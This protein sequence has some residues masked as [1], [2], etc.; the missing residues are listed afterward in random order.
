VLLDW[1]LFQFRSAT[2]RSKVTFTQVAP[3]LLLVNVE[4]PYSR[5]LG[6]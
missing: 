4:L 1:L 5:D 6:S 2:S 3:G